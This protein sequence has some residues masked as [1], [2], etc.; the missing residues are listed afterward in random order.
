MRRREF[1][2]ILSGGVAWPLFA[3][4]Q[5]R[6]LPLIGFLSGRSPAEAASA[7]GAFRQGL[8]EAGYFEGKNV[9]IEYRW[10]EGRYDQLPA[11]AADLVSRQVAVLAATGGEP[12][13]QAAKATT[14]TIPIVF[15]I[16]SD[17]VQLGLVASL[18]KPGTNITGVTFIFT[19][20]GT[21]RLELLRQLIPK[22][23]A[24][25]MLVNPN[26][27]PTSIEISDVQAGARY[28]GL[29]INVLNASTEPEIDTAF[30][31][32]AQQLTV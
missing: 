23:S 12:S 17:P 18:N 4:A 1:I 24:I 26:F 11:M 10:A 9:T 19:Q 8:G 16:G 5:Q 14:A 2:T 6:A 3:R 28:L 31:A 25:T 27:P 30:T 13:A 22:V 20:L 32:I 7:L 15:T 29:Q 21:K